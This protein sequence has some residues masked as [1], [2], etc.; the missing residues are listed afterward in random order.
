MAKNAIFSIKLQKHKFSILILKNNHSP[1]NHNI[2][3]V[4]AIQSTSVHTESL[5]EFSITKLM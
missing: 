3:S 2:S 4:G 1:L 5:D